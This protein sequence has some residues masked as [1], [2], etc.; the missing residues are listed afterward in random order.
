M[1]RETQTFRTNRVKAI[2]SSEVFVEIVQGDA[3]VST[4]TCLITLHEGEGVSLPDEG[5]IAPAQ[6]GQSVVYHVRPKR[7]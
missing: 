7:Q 1:I 5:W 2:P 4:R 3:L 6:A